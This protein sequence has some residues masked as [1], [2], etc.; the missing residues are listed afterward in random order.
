M[1]R[2]R[3]KRSVFICILGVHERTGADGEITHNTTCT[4]EGAKR[5]IPQI[6]QKIGDFSGLIVFLHRGYTTTTAWLRPFRLFFFFP[7]L[8]PL[9]L[10]FF[11]ITMS[12]I[13]ARSDRTLPSIPSID[14]DMTRSPFDASLLADR[15]VDHPPPCDLSAC[16][17]ELSARDATPAQ[18]YAC[19]NVLGTSSLATR[20]HTASTLCEHFHEFQDASRINTGSQH[21]REACKTSPATPAMRCSL[22]LAIWRSTGWLTEDRQDDKNVTDTVPC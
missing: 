18:P 13:T 9:A 4:G 6:R 21:K 7:P 11:P 5:K 2:I 19:W 20:I 3:A 22:I 17:A 14:T 15:R 8:A 10:F 12:T 16:C 1:A